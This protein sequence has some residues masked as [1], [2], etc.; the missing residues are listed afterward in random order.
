MIK[1]DI[2]LSHDLFDFTVTEFIKSVIENNLKGDVG[3]Q[4]S[5]RKIDS[6]NAKDNEC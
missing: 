3:K 6:H 1:L 4:V 5:P 2:P